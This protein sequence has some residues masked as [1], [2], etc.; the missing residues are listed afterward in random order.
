MVRFLLLR[1]LEFGWKTACQSILVHLY[2]FT[3]TLDASVE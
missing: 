3:V 2:Y 1:T